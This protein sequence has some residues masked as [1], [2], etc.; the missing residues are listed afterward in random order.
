MNLTSAGIV[1]RERTLL[2]VLDLALRFVFGLAPGTYAR[3]AALTLLPAFVLVSG[4]RW[5]LEWGWV[6]VWLVALAL[7]SWLQGGFTLAAGRLM[8]EDSVSAKEVLAEVWRRSLP[9]AG[10]LLLSRGLILLSSL[11][12]LTLPLAWMRMLYVHEA[13]L[14]EK[15]GGREALRRSNRFVEHHAKNAFGAMLAFVTG[16]LASIAVG[17]IFGQALVSFVLQSGE[18][19]SLLRDGG[20]PYALAGYFACLPFVATARFLTYIDT[21]MR[22]DGWD[23]QIRFIAIETAAAERV[24]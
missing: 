20:S 8:F 18:P 17:E 13:V 7:G 2:E 19:F 14:L 15:A 1:L 11:L 12:I 5:G 24:A 4:L 22:R 10:A 16:T 3:V 6:A 23:I 21:R 9:Y